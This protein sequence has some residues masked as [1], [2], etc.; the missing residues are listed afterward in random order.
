MP[1]DFRLNLI[2]QHFLRGLEPHIDLVEYAEQIQKSL[3]KLTKVGGDLYILEIDGSGHSYVYKIFETIIP[4]DVDEFL[5][6]IYR[7]N[8]RTLQ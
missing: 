6:Y 1:P 4:A 5:L 2:Q 7:A 3:R 8:A